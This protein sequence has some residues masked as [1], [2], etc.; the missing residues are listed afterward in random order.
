VRRRYPFVLILI[1]SV[2]LSGALAG[3]AGANPHRQ[4]FY[5]G[6]IERDVAKSVEVKFG[7]EA[8]KYI[9]RQGNT[10]ECSPEQAG[11]EVACKWNV[12]YK[13][14]NGR[15]KDKAVLE[16]ETELWTVPCGEADNGKFCWESR[17][18]ARWANESCLRSVHS[19]L[20]CAVTWRWNVG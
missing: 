18:Y 11:K 16:A 4:F 6:E 3:I 7:F 1:L 12:P 14:V 8:R 13:A 15:L 2:A 19:A 9:E 10:L 17:S 5:R 20:T